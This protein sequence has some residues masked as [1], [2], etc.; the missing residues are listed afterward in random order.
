MRA[1]PEPGDAPDASLE[2]TLEELK[3]FLEADEREVRARPEFKARLRDKL[4]ELV[5]DR[6]R[7]WRGD[8]P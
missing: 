3:D 2:A 4:W 6:S 8:Q 7:R 1:K 5:R